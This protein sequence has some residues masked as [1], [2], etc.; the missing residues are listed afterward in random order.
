[1]NDMTNEICE[2]AMDELDAVTGG[3]MISIGAGLVA[4]AA[5]S[6]AGGGGGGGGG[7]STLEKGN[8]CGAAPFGICIL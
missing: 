5:K 4:A 1:V 6:I 8:P 7:G 3:G 2:L